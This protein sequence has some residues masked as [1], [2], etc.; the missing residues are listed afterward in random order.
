MKSLEANAVAAYVAE[1]ARLAKTGKATEHTFRGALAT[2]F[3][4]PAKS[5][6]L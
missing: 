5:W 4:V 3:A 6:T 1:I 2:L